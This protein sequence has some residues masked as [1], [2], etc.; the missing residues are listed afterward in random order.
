MTEALVTV[1]VLIVVSRDH[2]QIVY[3]PGQR[4]T[5]AEAELAGLLEPAGPPIHTAKPPKL[6]KRGT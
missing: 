2:R 6:T 4:I 3:Q 1:P 5:R